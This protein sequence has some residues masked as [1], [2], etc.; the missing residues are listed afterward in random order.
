M[1]NKRNRINELVKYFETLGIEINLCKNRARGNKGFFKA[2]GE[3]FRIDIAKSLSEDEVLRV[4][5]H[6]FAH[7]IHYSYDKKLSSLNFILGNE[8]D[9][10]LLEELIRLTVDCILQNEISPLFEKKNQLKSDIKNLSMLIKASIP[11]FKL[12]IRCRE[13]ESKINKTCYKYLLKYD[14]VKI[15]S[16]FSA[17]IISIADLKNDLD[18]NA[19]NYLLIKSKQRA[20]NRI[21]SRISKYNKYYNSNTELFARSV[22]MFALKPQITKKMAPTVYQIY[23]KALDENTIPYFTRLINLLVI[24]F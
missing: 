16:G 1:D 3:C 18:E 23:Q 5:I 6:E 7:Y 17:K 8:L 24:K 11:D 9:E 22:E 12:S 19:K 15:L 13:L 2:K 4:L 21:N 20:M 14:R 10:N